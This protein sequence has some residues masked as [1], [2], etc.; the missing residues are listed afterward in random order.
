M[1]C[2]CERIELLSTEVGGVVLRPD[3][4]HGDAVVEDQVVQ[5]QYRVLDMVLSFGDWGFLS[6]IA[7]L[8]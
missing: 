8:H 2:V 3:V 7:H 6:V 1:N 4:E 5:L